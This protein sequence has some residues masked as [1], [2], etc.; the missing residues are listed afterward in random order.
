M[1]LKKKYL[2]SKK[3][4]VKKK[5]AHLYIKCRFKNTILSLN[6]INGGLY[7]QW[8]TQSF[9]G[10]SKKNNPYNI[11]KISHA[12][13]IYLKKAKIGRL[14][15]FVNGNGFGR[16]HVL[17]NLNKYSNFKT[18]YKQKIMRAGFIFDITPKVFNGCRK[19]S[20]KRR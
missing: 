14:N 19:R 11:E 8:S 12:L 9:K 4:K 17:K 16:F 10:R 6:K 5:L 3:K 2:Y 1:K 18:W 7:K 13:H 15:V 20:P